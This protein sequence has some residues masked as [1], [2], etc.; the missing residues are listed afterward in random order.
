MGMI[1]I[2]RE[3]THKIPISHCITFFVSRIPKFYNF[4]PPEAQRKFAR[5]CELGPR[6]RNQQMSSIT[7][8][9]LKSGDGRFLSHHFWHFCG[10]EIWFFSQIKFWGALHKQILKDH[11]WFNI[12]FPMEKLYLFWGMPRIS[13]QTHIHIA[14]CRNAVIICTYRKSL[15]IL[16]LYQVL[17]VWKKNHPFHPTENVLR[18]WVKSC[19]GTDG[20]A[21][22]EFGCIKPSAWFSCE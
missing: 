6:V 4:Q 7:W 18:V 22:L 2:F 17:Q 20:P 11:S 5:T 10:W 13:E 16:D 3:F 19:V 14:F 12:M 8:I 9:T 15:N 21:Q 1:S